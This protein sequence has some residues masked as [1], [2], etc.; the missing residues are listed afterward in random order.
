M[1]MHIPNIYYT[2]AFIMPN[3]VFAY[4]WRVTTHLS[5]EEA[6]ETHLSLR[7][8]MKKRAG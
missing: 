7:A 1:C 5:T 6:W 4:I 3:F 2:Y 8:G